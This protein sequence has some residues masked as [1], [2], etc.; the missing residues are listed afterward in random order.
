MQE[1]EIL[2]ITM[3]AEGS[4]VISSFFKFKDSSFSR[5]SQE[6]VMNARG[7]FYSMVLLINLKDSHINTPQINHLRS[8]QKTVLLDEN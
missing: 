6:N 5:C 1:S 8:F 7:S 2:K 3:L 4:L